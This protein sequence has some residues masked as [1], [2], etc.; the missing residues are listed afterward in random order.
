MNEIKDTATTIRSN[1]LKKLRQNDPLCN[2]RPYVT[3]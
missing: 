1:M 3:I 2:I